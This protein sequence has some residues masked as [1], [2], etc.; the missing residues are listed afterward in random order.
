MDL[1]SIFPIHDIIP[2]VCHYLYPREFV[3]L[4]QVSRGVRAQMDLYDVLRPV[5]HE[6]HT[7]TQ[8]LI[9]NEKV[10]SYSK[11]NYC[12]SLG[13]AQVSAASGEVKFDYMVTRQVVNEYTVLVLTCSHETVYMYTKKDHV[14]YALIVLVTSWT[15]YNHVKHTAIPIHVHDYLDR[16]YEIQ[17]G[18][19]QHRL[20]HMSIGDFLWGQ[21]NPSQ[22]VLDSFHRDVIALMSRT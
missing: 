16:L 10:L 12:L 5:D 17:C 1:T 4:R 3:A 18:T 8:Y 11:L 9:I 20:T 15:R 13:I 19:Y 7:Y 22:D 21:D 6:R 2:N 14:Q